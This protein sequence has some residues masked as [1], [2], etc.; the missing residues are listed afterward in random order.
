ATTEH[1]EIAAE[2]HLRI[3]LVGMGEEAGIRVEPARGPL[4]DVADH[5]ETAV[6]GGAARVRARRSRA[7]TELVDVGVCAGDRRIAPPRKRACH[8]FLP[9]PGRR[10]LPLD[11][12]GE[13]CAVRA[14]EGVGLE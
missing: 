3:L 9:V 2:E 13:A 10:L 1:L 7:A 11:L 6:R 12:G 4:P 14:S 8:S 5:P